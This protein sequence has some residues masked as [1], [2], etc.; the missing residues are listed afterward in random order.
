MHVCSIVEEQAG[1][2]GGNV[3]RVRGDEY[4]AEA[5]PHIN[6]EFVRPRFRCLESHQMTAQQTPHH[7]QSWVG[8]ELS[9]IKC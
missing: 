5:T 3:R 7:P 2:Q 8:M 4:H 6:Q 1:N 9:V